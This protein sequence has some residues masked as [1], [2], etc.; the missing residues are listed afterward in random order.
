MR[1][2]STTIVTSVRQDARTTKA[3]LDR[4][5]FLDL[6]VDEPVEE[7]EAE[8]GCASERRRLEPVETVRA[9]RRSV[10]AAIRHLVAFESIEEAPPTTVTAASIPDPP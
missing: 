5:K 3:R 10:G 8:V 7:R 1:V 4:E 6:I 9:S 2:A